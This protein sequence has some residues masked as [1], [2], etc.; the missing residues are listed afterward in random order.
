MNTTNIPGR[1]AF[2]HLDLEKISGVELAK[3]IRK[4]Y[5]LGLSESMCIGKLMKDMFFVRKDSPYRYSHNEYFLS[6]ADL[7]NTNEIKLTRF[8]FDLLKSDQDA[9]NHKQSRV[10][11]SLVLEA[12]KLG[13]TRS[14]AIN[15][16]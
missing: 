9:F 3:L 7:P 5:G 11:A 16:K 15:K 13:L 10:C 1:D 14:Q 12:Y 6:G 2:L 4:E 8:I